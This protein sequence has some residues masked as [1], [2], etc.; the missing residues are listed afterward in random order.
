MLV[1]PAGRRYVLEHWNPPGQ[2]TDWSGDGVHALF[3]RH[4]TP[5]GPGA[6]TVSVTVLDIRTGQT[7]SFRPPAQARSGDVQFTKPDG[8]AVLVGG[9]PLRRYSL[10]GALQLAYPTTFPAAGNPA[11]T[12][13][14]SGSLGYAESA[15]GAELALG[16][17]AGTDLVANKGKLLRFLPAPPGSSPGPPARWRQGSS[18]LLSC[19]A[20]LWS[21]PTAGGSPTQVVAGDG[22]G[23][24]D[25][26]SLPSGTLAQVGACG[27]WLDGVSPQGTLSRL[28]LPGFTR[29]T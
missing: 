23:V 5:G 8:T 24:L 7:T 25:E 4:A 12:I 9:V 29:S 26:W 18:V 20:A 28:S 15:D 17:A 16:T 27:T 14:A 22:L 11:T 13:S 3:V 6:S 1:D 10:A 21:Q 2:L 19:P